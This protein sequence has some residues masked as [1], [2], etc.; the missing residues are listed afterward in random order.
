MPTEDHKPTSRPFRVHSAQDL[1]AAVRHFRTSA[2]ITQ[3][4]LAARV[5]IHRSYL[6]A[7]EQGH[8]TEALDRLLALF[9]ELGVRITIAKEDW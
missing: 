2:G 1:G 4:D 5:G 7:L 3:T 9:R 8:A 6:A